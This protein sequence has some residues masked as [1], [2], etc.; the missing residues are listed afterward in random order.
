MKIVLL[1][2]FMINQPKHAKNVQSLTV[3]TAINLLVYVIH[4]KKVTFHQTILE[5]TNV[6]SA[7]KDALFVFI[8]S[9]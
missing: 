7:Q 3:N 1:I 4:V 5:K 2:N 9:L 8:I 6:L